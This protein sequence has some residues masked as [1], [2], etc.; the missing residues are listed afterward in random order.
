MRL[1]FFYL[2][3]SLVLEY[4]CYISEAQPANV[5]VF[6]QITEKERFSAVFFLF[7]FYFFSILHMCPVRM[8][9][10]G[11]LIEPRRFVS[12]FWDMPHRMGLGVCEDRTKFMGRTLSHS[13]LHLLMLPQFHIG[14]SALVELLIFSGH[15]IIA[16]YEYSQKIA[17]CLFCNS[18]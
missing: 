11:L 6:S 13:W 2:T 1:F 14:P 9:L 17:S 3:L 4:H 8:R 18:V 10:G 5:T 12:R 7:F 15:L 16:R